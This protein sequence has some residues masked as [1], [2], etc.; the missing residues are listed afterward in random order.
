ME[1]FH[2]WGLKTR[3][4]IFSYI[5]G[6]NLECYQQFMIRAYIHC[7]TENVAFQL[8]SRILQKTKKDLELIESWEI[9][10]MVEVQ[11]MGANPLLVEGQ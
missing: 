3:D 1:L 9:Y 8:L 10:R 7:V 2:T 4:D 5:K 11:G 6:K